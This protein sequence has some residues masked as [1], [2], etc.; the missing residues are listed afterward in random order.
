MLGYAFVLVVGGIFLY[1]GHQR[2]KAFIEHKETV[3]ESI[4][5]TFSEEMDRPLDQYGQFTFFRKR[6]RLA[7]KHLLTGDYQS[8]PVEAFEGSYAPFYFENFRR[9][10]S[11]AIFTLSRPLEPIEIYASGIS[12]DSKLKA[13]LVREMTVWEEFADAFEVICEDQKFIHS[14]DE[15]LIKMFLR[16]TGLML[17]IRNDLLLVAVDESLEPEKIISFLDLA[18]KVKGYIVKARVVC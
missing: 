12:D 1:L 11:C 14:L 3:A 7:T 2:Y 18:V 16:N 13:D 8:H 15:N 4:G 9:T 10:Y 17:E 6:P 5:L